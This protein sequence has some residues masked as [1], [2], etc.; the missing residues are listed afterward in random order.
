MR[1]F[2]TNEK[3]WIFG[4]F[5]YV[6]LPRV[7]VKPTVDQIK[8]IISDGDSQEIQQLDNEV[9]LFPPNT[10][11]VKCGRHIVFVGC[12]YHMP[13]LNDIQQENHQFFGDLKSYHKLDI[14]SWIK[15]IC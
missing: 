15:Y 2:V 4:L 3:T 12:K 6:A 8:I 9:F 5:F 14:Y 10:L 7:F 13:S 1:V 11:L